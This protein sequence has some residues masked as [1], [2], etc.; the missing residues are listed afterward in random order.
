ML[1][2]RKCDV[3]TKGVEAGDTADAEPVQDETNGVQPAESSHVFDDEG[4]G[5][6]GGHAE[7]FVGEGDL[8]VGVLSDELDALFEKP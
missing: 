4:E 5:V 1:K 8:D 6:P 2:S 7:V 3:A